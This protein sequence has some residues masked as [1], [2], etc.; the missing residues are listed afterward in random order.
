MILYQ[1]FDL[2]IKPNALLSLLTSLLSP[3]T[4]YLPFGMIFDLGFAF[5]KSLVSNE[6]V[7]YSPCL[8][9]HCNQDK[10]HLSFTI[11]I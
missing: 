10:V 1:Q 9:F 8:R 2:S 3:K 7:I 6:P 11:N 5:S 4:K